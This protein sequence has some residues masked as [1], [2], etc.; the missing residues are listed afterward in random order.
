MK[1][2]YIKS[3]LPA[4][5]VF[6]TFSFSS[7]ISDLDVNPTIDPSTSMELD[8]NALFAK[9]YA[10]MALTGQQ[11]PAGSGDIADIDEGTSDFI[12]Q[13]WNMNQL[14]TDESICSWGDA[15]V[16]E[17]NYGTWDASHGMVTALYYRL[18]FG[19]TLANYFLTETGGMEGADVALQRAEARFLR[20]LYYY[21]A[22]DLFGNVPFLTAVSAENAPQASRQEVFGFIEKE[23]L[24]DGTD[25]GCLA[26]MAEP[27]TNTY[28]RVDKAAGWLLL[29]R[30][31][32]NAEIYTGTAQWAKAAEYADKT[33][34]SGYS[35]ST[36]YRYL[37]MGDNNT[38]GAQNEMILPIL[39][40]GIDTQ[41]Y[42]GSL[43]LIASTHRTDMGDTNTS[44]NWAGNRAR[45]ELMQKFFLT[46][47]APQVDE[48]GM[49]AAAKDD[50]ALFFGIDRLLSAAD[51]ADFTNGYSC[52]KFTNARSTGGAGRDPK[53]ADMDV[54]F[55]RLAEAYLTLAEAKTRLGET[56][57][58]K[59]AIDA[60]RTR[61]NAAT[62]PSYSLDEICDEWSREFAFEGRRRMD[63]IRFGKF[64]G[65]SSYTWEWKGGVK[66][67]TNF[68][69]TKNV[70]GIPTKDIIANDNLVQNPG[71]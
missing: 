46:S 34:N 7:C 30:L 61:A 16:P 2:N 47:E 54:P 15:G 19:I 25:A 18:Y 63:L 36:N 68:S 5:A 52:A 23:L 39:Q 40:D 13:L 26:A 12:R 17:Y 56:S 57:A 67:G 44:E 49:V 58:A 21:Y 62:Q 66:D 3:F 1:L 59:T 53:F 70:Y 65:N 60:L 27:R 6:F 37:F 32:L 51:P 20:S 29:A 22:M 41:N 10:N 4:V 11:G 24:G 9:I 14:P 28:G 8:R 35:L 31:Y 71:Y 55:M 42:G 64:G 45:K 33:I 50:R 69:S 38:N 43:F 48:V